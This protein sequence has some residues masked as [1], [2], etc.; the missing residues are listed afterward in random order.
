MGVVTP[1]VHP[2]NVVQAL[3][4]T[5]LDVFDATRDI[6]QTLQVKDKR[7]YEASLRSKGYPTSRRLEYVEDDQLGKAE[8]LVMD[9]AAVTRQFE[10]GF[11][12]V[13]AQFAIGDVPSHI[14]L[15]AQIIALQSV[16]VKTFLY[17]PLSSDSISHQLSNVSAASRAAGTSSV[18]ILAALM[19]RQ[20]AA[21]PPTP[22]SSHSPVGQSKPSQAPPYPVTTIGSNSAS[23]SL[24]R[25]QQPIRPRSCSSSN[26]T[27]LDDWRTRPKMDRTD[28]DTVS[29]NGPTS[30]GMKSAPHDLYC[31]YAIDLQRHRDQQLASSI[32]SDSVPYC[33]HCKNILHL[34]PGKAWELVKRTDGYERVFQVSNR[35]VVKCHRDGADG[36]YS[37][38]LCSRH[39]D[40]DTVCGDVKALI[41]HIYE[42]HGVGELKHEEDITEV[43]ELVPYRR[44]DSGLAHSRSRRSAS[45]GHNSRRKS[46]YEREVDAYERRSSRWVD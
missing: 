20:Q 5:L 22:R 18:D 7:D 23:T 13:G 36:Q 38:V 43:V 45:V 46:A 24:V 6:Y 3:V 17:G 4:Y 1:P 27:I 39:A 31:L 11:Q 21:L 8:D 28:T 40:V 16:L 19:Q 33:P 41:K 29:M 35:F 37:C 12:K 15:Q 32:T 42:D 9:K 25:Y 26:T 30:Y 10:I 2:A 14:Q 34:S 44:R